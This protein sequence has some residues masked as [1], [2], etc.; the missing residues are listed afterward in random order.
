M[1]GISGENAPDAIQESF[2]FLNA[3]I[4]PQNTKGFEQIPVNNFP[5]KGALE[6]GV[7]AASRPRLEV[8]YIKPE[9]QVVASA[10]LGLCGVQAQRPDPYGYMDVT[11]EEDRALG[12]LF[13]KAD[14]DELCETP[15][16][17]LAISVRHTALDIMRAMNDELIAQAYALVGNYADATSSAGLTAKEIP[18]INGAGHVN[19]AAMAAV[20]SQF[21][22]QHTETLPIAVGGDILGIWFDT[23]QMGG[24]GA[25]A[26]GASA[27]PTAITG[28]VTSFV[29]FQVDSVIQGIETDTDSHL[30]AWI[31]GGYQLL[32]W[33]EY[34][35]YK[36]ELG[37]ADYTETTITIDGITFDFSLKYD[38]CAHAWTYEL[39]KQFD[40]FAIPDAAY[41]QGAAVWD[42]NRRLHWKL[43]CGDFACADYAI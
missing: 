30:L 18:L 41:T 33:F 39:A 36:E 8:R 1:D 4:S 15:S 16:E 24:L 38:E 43:T 26:I 6:T 28:G 19:P 7:G 40:L 3:L 34:V 20:K 32:E 42:F 13:S 31:P 37:K 22:R 5:G 17:R 9:R 12:G 29:D 10:R 35:G 27:S 2:G 25:N 21:R 23:R 14:F 11:V